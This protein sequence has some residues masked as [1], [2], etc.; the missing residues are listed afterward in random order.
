M[1][2]LTRRDFLRILALGA[3]SAASAQIL[4]ACGASP[5]QS[6]KTRLPAPSPLP[7]ST[8]LAVARGGDDPEALV[9]RAIEALGGMGR[10]VPRGARVVIKPN[11]CISGRSYEYAVTTN[12]WVV[13]ALVKLAREA[14][15]ARVLVFDNP[16]TGSGEDAFASSGI[17]AQVGAAGGE[18]EYVASMKFKSVELPGALWLKKTA[19][20]DEVLNADV[21]INVPIAKH[22]N[23]TGLTLGMKNQLGTLRDRPEV[24]ASI[25]HKLVDLATFLRPTLTVVDAVRILVANGPTGGSLDD[26]QKLDTVIA[27]HDPVAADAFTTRLFGWTDPNRLLNVQYG[28]EAGIGRNDLENLTIQEIPVG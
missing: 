22:H 18:L 1:K 3:G 24:H 23:L 19:V 26:V 9:R 6:V 21:L 5:S 2:S 7:G 15:A 20:Y 28:A 11:L 12:P 8:Y 17:A 27:T 13:G 14:G 4:A 10:F 16:T 25:P